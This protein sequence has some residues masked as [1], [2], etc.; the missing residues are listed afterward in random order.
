MKLNEYLKRNKYSQN[1][2]A[3]ELEVTQAAVS[4]WCKGKVIPRPA[5]M[6][7]ILLLTGGAVTPADFYNEA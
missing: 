6:K 5:V 4:R 2:L 7:K 3:K 1:K